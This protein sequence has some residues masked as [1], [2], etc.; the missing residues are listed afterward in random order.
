MA[1]VI[2]RDPFDRMLIAQAQC[3]DLT[4]ATRDPLCQKY[5]VAVLPA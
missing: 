5:D 4:L 3:E 1:P 2:H